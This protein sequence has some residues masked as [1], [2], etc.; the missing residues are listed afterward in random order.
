MA[1]KRKEKQVPD[2]LLTDEEAFIPND[3]DEAFYSDSNNFIDDTPRPWVTNAKVDKDGLSVKHHLLICH[4]AIIAGCFPDDRFPKLKDKYNQ[5]YKERNLDAIGVKADSFY[6]SYS[7]VLYAKVETY[8][9]QGE[10]EVVRKKY[11]DSTLIDD[12]TPFVRQWYPSA[13]S[14]ILTLNVA[15]ER[16][17]E[18]HYYWIYRTIRGKY[19]QEFMKAFFKEHCPHLNYD[20]FKYQEQNRTAVIPDDVAKLIKP[21]I[22]VHYPDAL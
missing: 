14:F 16:F 12:V 4:I 15:P 13:E 20:T 22:Q 21:Y 11:I 1:K 7:S 9:E 8:N 10:F 19:P 17:E 3:S 6:K 5:Y 18:L 2:N